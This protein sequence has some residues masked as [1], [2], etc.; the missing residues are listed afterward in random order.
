MP[1]IQL[2]SGSLHYVDT[3]EGVPVVLLHANP[4]DSLDFQAVIPRLAERF[5]V[6]APDWPGYGASVSPPDDA[7]VDALYYYRVLREFLEALPLPPAIFIGNSLGGNV[8][9]RLA[10]E[11]PGSVLGLV[12]VAPGGFTEQN[13][14][15]RSFCK[16]MSSRWSLSPRRFAGLYLRHRTPTVQRMLE[17]AST[18]QASD[19]CLAINRSVWR[20]FMDPE[21]DLREKARAITAPTLLVFGAGDPVISAKKDGEAA[22]R[23][24]PHAQFVVLPSGHAPF[25]EVPQMFLHE[26]LPLLAECAEERV[27]VA[28]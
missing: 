12:L 26:V 16:L 9:A 4:G 5:R 8:A 6:V 2:S 20:G 24:I 15:S 7:T 22:T 23:A 1:L 10:I 11:M 27:E 17:R 18:T 25:A 28:V 19:E 14:V 13:F 3:G 21:H